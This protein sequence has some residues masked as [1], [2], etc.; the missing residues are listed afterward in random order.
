MNNPSAR[1]DDS[2]ST[3]LHSP[4]VTVAAVFTTIV[5]AVGSQGAHAATCFPATPLAQMTITSHYGMRFHPLKNKRLLHDGT[6]FRAAVGTRIS[7]VHPGKVRFVGTM[8]GGGNTVEVMGTDGIVSRYMHANKLVAQMG[9]T[10]NQGDMIA[11]SGKTGQPNMAPHLH[12]ST[13]VV[14]NRPVNPIQFFCGSNFAVSPGAKPP[15]DPAPG[16]PIVSVATANAGIPAT[17]PAGA[18]PGTPPPAQIPPGISGGVAPPMQTFPS[19]DDMS[20]RDFLY[21][22]TNKR[23]TNPQW[24]QELID[25]AAALRADPKNAGV[26]FSSSTMDPKVYMLR[27]LNI[28]MAL[29]NL[30]AS[31]RYTARENIEA[32]IAA[33][34]SLDAKSYSEKVLSLLRSQATG[35]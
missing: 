35:K 8:S 12:L 26:A 15:L 6:D 30:M 5:I 19:M 7:S 13:Y 28:T 16:D 14:G 34:L 20:V 22:E 25:P 17:A 11:E 9:A 33:F 3:V 1:I 24:Y 10:V 31:E 4:R 29:D 18:P 32:R 27:E 2:T 21:S 23:F